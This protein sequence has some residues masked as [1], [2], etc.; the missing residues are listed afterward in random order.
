[1]TTNTELFRKLLTILEAPA[2]Q[3]PTK[4]A[5]PDVSDANISGAEM[6]KRLDTIT[7]RGGGKDIVPG[8][9][10]QIAPAPK[11]TPAAPRPAPGAGELDSDVLNRQ[12]QLTQRQLSPQEY[13]QK[14]DQVNQMRQQQGQAPL[15]VTPP[16]QVATPSPQAAAPQ[17]VARTAPAGQAAQAAPAKPAAPAAKADPSRPGMRPGGDPK[18]Y[19]Q[20]KELISKGAKIAA[21]GIMGP[22]TQAAI[23]QFSAPATP[24]TPAPTPEPGQM[25]QIA[26]VPKEQ[27]AATPTPAPTQPQATAA[28]PE[29]G[30]VAGAT[31][32][33]PAAP[34]N[35]AA[36]SGR[37]TQ[38][39]I[40]PD[41]AQAVLDNGSPSDIAALGGMQRLQQLA[42]VKPTAQSRQFQKGP[43]PATAPA[44]EL[45][46]SPAPATA[47]APELQKSPAPA[48]A[49]AAPAKTGT[50]SRNFVPPRPV[51]IQQA[52]QWARQYAQTHNPDGSPKAN[53]SA[54]LKAMLT[55]AGLR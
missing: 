1:M 2:D 26:P 4:R 34:V 38:M 33:T 55:I 22:Q 49:P 28:K 7:T 42:G 8:Q 45:Q 50:T 41:Q 32:A 46:K 53:E 18:V 5:D 6:Q 47:P 39:N 36:P 29:L 27:P 21:D 11:A 25:N 51:N 3:A 9:R 44:P 20:Q 19:D 37:S 17:A 12:Q 15:P 14:M 30:T 16:S 35:P 48:T 52:R 10:Q 31:K 43:A 24:A 54:D 23:K 40:T 13:Q